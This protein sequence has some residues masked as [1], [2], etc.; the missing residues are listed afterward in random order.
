MTTFLRIGQVGAASQ[1]R[2]PHGGCRFH[3]DASF[4]PQYLLG[5][6]DRAVKGVGRDAA[7][8]RIDRCR[9]LAR[10]S[11]SARPLA[12][13]RRSGSPLSAQHFPLMA[14]IRFPVTSVKRPVGAYNPAE[15]FV[16][17]VNVVT[18]FR[19]GWAFRDIRIVEGI[20]AGSRI[21]VVMI[22]FES[23]QRRGTR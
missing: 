15:R 10:G 21:P 4:I 23:I 17:I 5:L 6:H 20:R 22:T 2:D 19:T 14:A 16:N 8:R 1:H 3:H 11:G 7:G 18:A 12:P 9:W 13:R